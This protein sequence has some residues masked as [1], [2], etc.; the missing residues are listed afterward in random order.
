M[1]K[2]LLWNLPGAAFSTSTVIVNIR[3]MKNKINLLATF[4]RLIRSVSTVVI[5]VTDESLGDACFVAAAKRAVIACVV[6]C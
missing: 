3:K 2:I 4:H 5:V 1:Y 6:G